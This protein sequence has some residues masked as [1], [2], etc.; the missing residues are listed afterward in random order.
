MNMTALA[1]LVGLA[2]PLDPAAMRF[3]TKPGTSCRGCLFAGQRSDV[4]KEAT[5]VAL[6]AELADCD[7]GVIYIAV[8]L[9][10]RQLTIV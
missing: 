9:D 2:E 1:D 4:C 10:P 3:T 7:L 6:R 5:K 8:P